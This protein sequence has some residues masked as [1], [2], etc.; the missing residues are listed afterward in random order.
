MLWTLILGNLI[1]ALFYGILTKGKM[2][3][4]GMLKNKG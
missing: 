3:F 2:D 1:F 4:K